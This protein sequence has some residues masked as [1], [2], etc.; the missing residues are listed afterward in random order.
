MKCY[1][2]IDGGGSGSRWALLGADG[3]FRGR[4]DGPPIQVSSM[5]IEESAHAV[6][7]LAIAAGSEAGV[8][9]PVVAVV[10]LAGAGPK[11]TRQQLEAALAAGASLLGTDKVRVVSDIEI[12]AAAALTDGS[13]VALWSGTGSFAV[14]RDDDGRL[15]RTGGRGPLLGDEGSAYAIALAAARAAVRSRDRI[16]P[17]TDL[18]PC[19][20]DALD[21]AGADA[22]ASIMQ[23]QGPGDIAALFP[24]VI[25]VAADGDEPARSILDAGA[26]ALGALASAS[27]QRA[28]RS[29]ENTRVVLGGGVLG[30]QAYADR[31]VQQLLERGFRDVSRTAQRQPCEGAALLARA[32]H[33][34]QAPMCSWV[35]NRQD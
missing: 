25:D 12:A 30:Q 5:G 34:Q 13:G 26:E 4:G 3:T 17:P 22:I 7:K 11:Q 28:G 2:G 33:Q 16:G 31:V 35:E 18:L 23:T 8:D 15:W 24:I 29:P 20:S 19:L 27:C 9:G 32:W 14:A 6:G 1:L 10:G 21:A